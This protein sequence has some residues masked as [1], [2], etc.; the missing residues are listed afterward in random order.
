MNWLLIAVLALLV[1]FAYAG[2]RRGMMRILF[3]FGSL[4]IALLVSCIV[5]PYVTSY[6]KEHTG[7]YASVQEKTLEY[8]REKSESAVH[9]DPSGRADTTVSDTPG[10]EITGNVQT[11]EEEVSEKWTNAVAEIEEQL[12]IPEALREQIEKLLMQVETKESIAAEQV[13]EAIGSKMADLIVSALAF[14]I[15]LLL[16]RFILWVVYQALNIVSHLPVL[17]GINQTLGMI[18]GLAEGLLVVWIFF[19]FLTCIM[20]TAFGRECLQM[21]AG[22]KI[23]SALYNWN[24]LRYLF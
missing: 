2:H 1:L 24:I 5:T 14:V 18:L 10:G 12:Q 15:T 22:S 11:G 9:S 20:Q 6:I 21:I 8:V 19:V 17:H 3:S 7:I 16:V 4:V 13:Q 23:L